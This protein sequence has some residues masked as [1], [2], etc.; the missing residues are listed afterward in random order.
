MTFALA[1]G[2]APAAKR[3]MGW[4]DGLIRLKVIAL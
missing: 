3:R 1:V 2:P 4:A